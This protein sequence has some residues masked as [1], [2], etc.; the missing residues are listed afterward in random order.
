MSAPDFLG[1]IVPAVATPLLPGGMDID[2][3]AARRLVDF[4][5]NSGAH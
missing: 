1:G 2:V 4:L 3:E 5:L